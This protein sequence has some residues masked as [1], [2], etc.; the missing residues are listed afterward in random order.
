MDATGA[1]ELEEVGIGATIEVNKAVGCA[2]DNKYVSIGTT[3]EV[4]GSIDG[5]AE[6]K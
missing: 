4:N 1:G 5:T 2:R 3:A 6:R